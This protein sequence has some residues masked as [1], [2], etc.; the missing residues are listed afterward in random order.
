MRQGAL[1]LVFVPE[2]E[3]PT[4]I[5]YAIPRRTG[6]AVVRNRVRRRLRHLFAELAATDPDR[7]PSGAMLV[8]VGPEV[9][10]RGTEELRNDVVRML[11]A[12]QARTHRTVGG[13]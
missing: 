1:S 12:L 4:R 8:L 6:G 2:D 3:G 7:V 11:E 5:G 9:V 13:R 10:P